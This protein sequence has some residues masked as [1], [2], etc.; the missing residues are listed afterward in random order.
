MPNWAQLFSGRRSRRAAMITAFHPPATFSV[1][2]V[3]V[4][5]SL[6]GEKA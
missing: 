2:F 4:L 5:V 3:M 1:R 6:A